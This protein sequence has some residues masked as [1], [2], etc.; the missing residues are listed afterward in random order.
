[1][2]LYQ[3]YRPRAWKELL[4]QNHIRI[5]LQNEL[6]SNSV[7]H[8]YLFTGPRGVG[9]TS[10]ARLLAKSVTCENFREDK[11]PC[12]TCAACQEVQ[13]GKALD[14]IEI[15][16]ASH[17]GVDNVRENIIQNARVAPSRLKYK[18]FIIDEVHML[19]ASA[20]NALLK[21]LE[22]PPKQTLFILA[23]TEIHKV[24]ETIISRC[25]RFDF[26]KIST[27][28]LV[29]ILQDIAQKEERMIESAVLKIIA[30]RADGCIRDALSLLEQIFALEEKNI[31]LEIASLVLPR[32]DTESLI[33][34]FETFVRRETGRALDHIQ[35]LAGEG[36][37]LIEFAKT[38]IEF[39]RQML[40]LKIQ[41]K[42]AN[43]ITFDLTPD[44]EAHCLRL[45]ESLETQKL[46][47]IL[48]VFIEKIQDMKKV[49]F[50]QLPLELAV[51]QITLGQHQEQNQEIAHM[52]SKSDTSIQNMHNTEKIVAQEALSKV[53]AVKGEEKKWAEK[54]SKT[55]SNTI[56]EAATDELQ[57]ITKHWTKIIK[58]AQQQNH[59]LALMLKVASLAAFEN[60]ILTLGFRYQFYHD[61]ISEEKHRHVIEEVIA[62]VIGKRI[63]IRCEVAEKFDTQPVWEK[64]DNI[65]KVP[66]E[67]VQNVWD[68]ALNTFGGDVVQKS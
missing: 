40:L 16:A 22:E 45:L 43:S 52:Q 11:E 23:T 64:S 65:E 47:W 9:K 7:T 28:H 19:S 56:S 68:L 15:D 33:T 20:F 34:L 1:M 13:Q 53:G 62:E 6:A 8:A 42:N 32:S 30:R 35:K 31:T 36:V 21:I 18:V 67:E 37:N 51:I 49:E 57:S 25:Q 12:N 55:A 44:K 5:T 24:P 27:E 26:R 38:M 58:K 46:L 61:R 59:S 48:D 63:L 60:D 4:G 29:D 66:K 2:S 3:K 17:T 10:A 39:V 14:I 54:K 41:G 50:V